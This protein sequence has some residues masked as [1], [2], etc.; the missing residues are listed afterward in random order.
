MKNIKFEIAC[1]LLSSAGAIKSIILRGRMMCD[2]RPFKEIN[3]SR[4]DKIFFYNHFNNLIINDNSCK[5]MQP[6]QRAQTFRSEENTK[7]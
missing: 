2:E 1:K 3:I 7:I 6:K 4:E 5:T